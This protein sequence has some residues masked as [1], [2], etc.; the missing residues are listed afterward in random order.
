M[1]ATPNDPPDKAVADENFADWKSHPFLD[2]LSVEHVARLAECAMPTHFKAGQII[3]REGEMANR[4]YLVLE[5]KVAL[6]ADSA[7][8]PPVPVDS[9]TAGDVLGWSWLFPPYTWNFSARSLEP[10]RAIFFYGT[11]LRER[12]AE[13]PALGYELMKRTSA[14]LVRRLQVT[15]QELVCA[16]ATLGRS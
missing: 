1:T 12:C 11:W 8:R 7:D 3:F 13:E 10:G 6:E 4:F 16:V 15:R 5:G 14:V 9:V 2:G